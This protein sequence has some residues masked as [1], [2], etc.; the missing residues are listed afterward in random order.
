[1]VANLLKVLIYD[2]SFVFDNDMK[3]RC[4]RALQSFAETYVKCSYVHLLTGGRCVNTKA[5]HAKGHQDKYGEFLAEGSFMTGG[6]DSLTFLEM[7]SK[8]VS[9]FLRQINDSSINQDRRRSFAIEHHLQT[10]QS[11]RDSSFWGAEGEC[12]QATEGSVSLQRLLDKLGCLERRNTCFGCL[13]GRPEF[14]LPCGHILCG[15]CIQDFGSKSLDYPDLVSLGS[16]VLCCSSQPSGHWPFKI[17]LKP[18]ASGIRVLSLD[19]VGVRGIIELEVLRRLE[20]AIGLS[21]PLWYFFDL[22]V[23]SSAGGLIAL[24]LG[25]QKWDSGTCIDKFQAL[26]QRGFLKKFL[27]TTRGVGVVSR[28]LRGSIYDSAVLEKALQAVFPDEN[29]FGLR[30]D[31]AQKLLHCPRVAITTTVE[32]QCKLFTNYNCGGAEGTDY[33]SSS[34]STWE[35]ARCTS[36]VPMYFESFRPGCVGAECRDG[37]LTANNPIQFATNEGSRIWGNSSPFDI[38]LSVG[39]G[40]APEPPDTPSPWSLP[41]RIRTQF[42]TLMTNIS[43]EDKWDDFKRSCPESTLSRSRRLNVRFYNEKEPALDAI[44]EMD[45]MAEKAKKFYFYNAQENAGSRSMIDSP[46]PDGLLEVALCLRASLFFFDRPCIKTMQESAVVVLEGAIYCRLDAG[47]T[48][49]RL[50]LGKT[51]EFRI[52]GIP[53]KVFSKDPE[54]PFKLD[55]K[56]PVESNARDKLLLI[57]VKF[58][59]GPFAAIS[60]FPCA[61][62]VRY[63]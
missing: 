39:S 55:V 59:D 8:K 2:P 44:N 3:Q 35:V 57:E 32:S 28:W 18:R 12:W 46:I 49:I 52:D 58:D 14:R 15:G 23:G 62:K 38:I 4:A 48:A 29:F 11:A 42:D 40:W 16:C 25:A 24:S 43:G 19:G 7:I 33:L 56:L 6:F 61:L 34:L 21:L 30:I 36:A 27:M 60:G 10:L 45:R 13:F 5:G 17:R 50:L 9:E 54:I 63:I 51:L 22:I 37:G 20:V 47:T 26:C 31:A 41:D 1:M 53:M